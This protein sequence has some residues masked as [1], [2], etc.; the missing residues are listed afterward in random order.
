MCQIFSNLPKN[1]DLLLAKR[2]AELSVNYSKIIVIGGE[3]TPKCF[4]FLLFLLGIDVNLFQCIS[5]DITFEN[6]L[7]F[8]HLKKLKRL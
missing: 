3:I 8:D 7:F 6:Y 4:F 1:L 2:L 5:H